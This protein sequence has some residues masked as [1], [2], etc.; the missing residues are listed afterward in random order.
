MKIR[1]NAIVLG[2]V[3]TPSLRSVA[4]TPEARSFIEGLYALKR[5][6]SVDEVAQS[7]VYLASDASSFTTGS[8]LVVDGGVSINRS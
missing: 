8:A 1:A 6:A 4:N 2:G 7:F 3:D 5:I